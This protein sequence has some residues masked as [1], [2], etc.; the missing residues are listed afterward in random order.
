MQDNSKRIM[1]VDGSEV[2]RTI[3]ARILNEEMPGATIATCGTAAEATERLEEERFDL[4]STA[5]MLP[6]RDGLELSRV[7]RGSQHHHYTPII[8]IS[9]DA[10]ERLLREGFA[11]GVTDYFDKSLGYQAFAQF[12]QEFTERNAGL[13]GRI[14]YVEDS[15][16]AAAYTMRLMEHHGLQVVHT[17]TAEDALEQLSATAPGGPREHESFDIIVTDFYLKG[18]MTGGDLLHAVRAKFHYSQQEMPVLMVTVAENNEK[19]VDVFHAGA[20]D[21]VTKPIVEET[22]MA[23]IRSLLLIKQQFVALKRQSETMHRLA[24]TDT[25][26]R[27]YN[28]RYLLDHGDQFLANPRNHPVSALLLDIDHFKKIND[29][30]GHITGDRVLEAL[31]KLLKERIPS[32]AM[33]VRFGGEEFA[34]L[35]PRSP[36]RDA[37]HCAEK[38]RA[39]VESLYPVDIPITISIGLAC[40]QNQPELNLTQLL[41]Q[42]DKAL[43]A[44]KDRGRNR[45][46]A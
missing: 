32:D 37:H 44:A 40:T 3:I 21:F 10:D 1:V 23:R 9:G 42:A 15:P 30:L 11:A 34:L 24:I 26:T 28:K 6:D 33:A 8:V 39:E 19:Q 29:N 46:C 27:V 20:N 43:Y 45:V 13:V 5:L 14:L 7:V 31:G 4:I 25:L 18:I 41:S 36:Q 17:T 12:I 38:L 35:V 22:L 16:S 2:A